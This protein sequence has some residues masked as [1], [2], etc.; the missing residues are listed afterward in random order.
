MFTKNLVP[1]FKEEAVTQ[2]RAKNRNRAYRK[3]DNQTKNQLV[4]Q[5]S[6]A[7]KNLMNFARI[8]IL[9]PT[10]GSSCIL[11]FAVCTATSTY[12]LGRPGIL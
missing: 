10:G 7:F 11:L 1:I 8:S 9:L 12:R 4:S 6:P 3:P 5:P 2:A